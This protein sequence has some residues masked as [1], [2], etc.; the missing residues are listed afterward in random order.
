M[1]QYGRLGVSAKDSRRVG[2][3]NVLYYTKMF[4][5]C[6]SNM[7]QAPIIMIIRHAEKA[8]PEAGGVHESGEDDRHSLAVSG[9]QRAGALVPLFAPLTRPLPDPRLARPAHIIVEAADAS[10]SEPKRSKR[11][12][13]TLA[14][15]VEMLRIEPDLR[16]GKGQ[17]AEAAAEA[18]RSAGP[19]LIAWEHHLLIK[20]ARE[21]SNDPA[22][23]KKWPKERYD[24]VFVFRLQPDGV[25]YS[26]EQVPQLLL[27]GDDEAPI[28][29][30]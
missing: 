9:W 3:L 25:S 12:V 23:P 16:F 30:T 28:P 15:L 26:F 17:E 4:I 13:Q 27:A 29:T 18:K 6:R 10:G 11:E 8:A 21:I 14:P 22:I 19:V 5:I 1:G 2:P 24:I 20:L 7:S